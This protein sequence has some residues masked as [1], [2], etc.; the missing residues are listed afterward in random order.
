MAIIEA[1]KG[2]DI[3]VW[4]IQW[5]KELALCILIHLEAPY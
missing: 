4:T 1:I 2:T 5:A 3:A